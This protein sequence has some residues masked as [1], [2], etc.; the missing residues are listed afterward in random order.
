MRHIIQEWQI[1]RD[2]GNIKDGKKSRKRD[3]MIVAQERGGGRK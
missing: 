1:K 2:D 3:E